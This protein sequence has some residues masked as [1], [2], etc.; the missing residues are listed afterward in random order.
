MLFFSF[1]L[2]GGERNPTEKD[3]FHVTHHT[4]CLRL[5]ILCLFPV[6]RLRT[7]SPTSVLSTSIL[8]SFRWER[9]WSTSWSCKDKPHFLVPC[10]HKTLDNY[11]KMFLFFFKFRLKPL[12]R[13]QSGREIVYKPLGALKRTRKRCTLEGTSSFH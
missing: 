6:T 5:I 10:C 9:H 2:L 1:L 8:M 13:K 11:Y 3:I 12:C 7:S 4:Q